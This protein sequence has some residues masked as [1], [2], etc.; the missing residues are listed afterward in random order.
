[1]SKVKPN[2]VMAGEI[3]DY[4]TIERFEIGNGEFRLV[5]SF[6]DVTLVADE[7]AFKIARNI[8]PEGN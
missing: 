8:L 5:G 6:G 1:M 3:P 2:K 7:W 4:D